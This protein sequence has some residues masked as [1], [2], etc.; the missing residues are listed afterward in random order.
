M[1]KKQAFM[2]AMFWRALRQ[3]LYEDAMP[4]QR[5]RFA[6]KLT[7]QQAAEIKQRLLC[8]EK[9]IALAAEYGVSQP[10]ISYYA[11]SRKAA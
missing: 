11:G 8:G 4:L 2:H 3:A 6:K 9:Q 1:T 5:H 10:T 7:E